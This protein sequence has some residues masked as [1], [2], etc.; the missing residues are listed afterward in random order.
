MQL[1]RGGV[2]KNKKKKLGSLIISGSWN[3]KVQIP[4]VLCGFG[5]N[6]KTA[7]R[8]F[9][10]CLG[11]P[12]HLGNTCPTHFLA[13]WRIIGSAGISEISEISQSWSLNILSFPCCKNL[14]EGTSTV[15]FLM[16]RW[17]MAQCR[18]PI[19]APGQFKWGLWR[20][21][22]NNKLLSEVGRCA[23]ITDSDTF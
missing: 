2:A 12:C 16:L 23:Q 5:L 3:R 15:F 9:Q 21:S 6:A 18:W 7:D 17:G 19:A 20:K 8:G 13:K 1:L 4:S 22:Y 14:G 10:I 11:K